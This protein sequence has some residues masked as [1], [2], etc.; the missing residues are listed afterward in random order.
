MDGRYITFG[1]WDARRKKILLIVC[2]PLLVV[3]CLMAFL[4]FYLIQNSEF[5]TW[6]KYLNCV[7]YTDDID[8][9]LYY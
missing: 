7:P 1:Q 2:M 3:M 6:C 4:T 9:S 8:C 5:C